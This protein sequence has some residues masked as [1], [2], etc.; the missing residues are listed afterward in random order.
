[1]A[2]LVPSGVVTVMSTVPAEAAGA[3]ATMEVPA[4]LTVKLVAAAEP[5]STE[6]APTKSTPLTVTLVPP[7]PGPEAGFTPVTAGV[8]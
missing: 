7:A 5:K 1:M 2:G 3:M 8:S 6:V 4:A